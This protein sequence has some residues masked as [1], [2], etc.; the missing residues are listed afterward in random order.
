MFIGISVTM[1]KIFLFELLI[2]LVAALG[3]TIAIFHQFFF[4]HKTV[5]PSNLLVTEYSPWRYE[6]VPEYPN[7]P[8]NKPIGFDIIRE[9]YPDRK[10]LQDALWRGVLPLWNPYIYSGAPFMAASTPA[11]WYPLSWIAAALPTIEGWNFLVVIQ[12][13]LSIVFMYI[14]LRSLKFRIPLAAFGSF[15]YALSGWMVVYWQESVVIEHSFLWLPLA[16]YASNR[17]WERYDD[18]FDFFLL[19]FSL[20]SSAFAGFLQMSAY[21]YAVV[22]LWNVY[23]FLRLRGQKNAARSAWVI[24]FAVLCSVLIESIQLI[25]SIQAFVLSP[26]GTNDASFVFRQDLLPFRNIITLFAPDYWGNPATYNYFGGSGFYFEKTIF[27]GIIPLLFAI[28]AM[29]QV[30]KKT[31]IFWTIIGVVCFSMCFALPT[32]WVP[33]YLKIPILS[34]S[35]PT[36]IFAVSVFS[37]SI[38][39]CYGLE[40][41]L[42]KPNRKRMVLILLSFC[43]FLG[44]GWI[45]VIGLWCIN[46]YYHSYSL[47]CLGKT[48]VVCGELFSLKKIAPYYATVSLRNLIVPTAF[49]LAGWGLLFVSRFSKRDVFVYVCVLTAASGIY[50]ADKYVYFGENRFVYPNLPVITKLTDLAG[51]DRI[52]GYGNAFIEKNL[53]EYFRWFSTDGYSNLSSSRY[54]E[55]LST[56]ANKGK[57][58]GIIR[59]SDTDLY[60]M[61]EIDPLNSSNPYRLRI[62]S[63]FGVKYILESKKGEYTDLQSTEKR[64]P[65]EM[66]TTVWEDST[67]RIWQYRQALPRVMFL[68]SYI[69][70][71]DPQ[72]IIDTLY[73]PAVRLDSTVV[74][75][76]VPVVPALPKYSGDQ[77]SSA[78]ITSYGLNTVTVSIASP[79]SGFVV[80]TDNYYPGWTATIDGKP[81][82]LYRADYTLRAVEAPEG[83]H[84]VVFTYTPITLTIGEIVTAVGIILSIVIVCC[85]SRL[86]RFG[87]RA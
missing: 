24:I 74:L 55:L 16:L 39:S 4:D 60:E 67:W 53:P 8:P 18:T 41:F 7:G 82:E 11:V 6:P 19:L 64:F 76:R 73:D 5:F 72:Q 40:S 71:S 28:Y 48:L 81:T 57:L 49:L 12:P 45:V 84:T 32:S 65:P 52:W 83:K 75:E 1:K 36:R 21:V 42:S 31:V 20:V 33:Y 68:R 26:R 62:M 38:L 51:Y 66:F 23:C 30:R 44:T 70:R 69:V 43:V 15:V 3:I 14:F 27:I 85:M 34:T 54:A 78:T 63:L 10:L 13:I 22:F 80:L 2:V 17:V 87:H 9:S 47:W 29:L 46:H 35:Y 37:F 86:I 59:R 56:I 25:P 77:A 61:S 50:F 79:V 58:G